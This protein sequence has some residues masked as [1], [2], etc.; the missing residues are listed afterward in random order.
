MR[1]TWMLT[2]TTTL[3]TAMA[4]ARACHMTRAE[5][6]GQRCVVAHPFCP[7]AN[8]DPDVHRRQTN[9]PSL[10]ALPPA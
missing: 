9:P 3:V 4:M 6:A 5:M 7:V 2:T 1:L 8:I 10:F